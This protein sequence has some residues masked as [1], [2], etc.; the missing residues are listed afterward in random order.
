[1][2]EVTSAPEEDTAAVD[3][4]STDHPDPARAIFSAKGGK[5]IFVRSN[6]K[7][8]P[9][10]NGPFNQMFLLFS[11]VASS[12]LGLAH[13]IYTRYETMKLAVRQQWLS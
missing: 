5:D 8:D 11:F 7:R 12:C 13:S 1:M 10:A 3:G 4:N 6:I 2:G 9:V